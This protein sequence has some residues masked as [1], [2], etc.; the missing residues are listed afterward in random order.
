MGELGK[1]R[2]KPQ[3]DASEQLALQSRALRIVEESQEARTT[4][5]T[6]GVPIAVH[7]YDTSTV[8][9]W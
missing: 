9:L 8:N 4:R 7:F 1:I 5:R 6:E 3:E 2:Y